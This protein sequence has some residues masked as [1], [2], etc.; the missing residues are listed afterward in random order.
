LTTYTVT[1]SND[2]GSGSLRQAILD[3]N[4]HSGLN[5]IDFFIAGGYHIETITPLAPLPAITNR[6]VLDGTTQVAGIP[7]PGIE[8]SGASAGG[9]AANGLTITAGH[10]TVAGLALT[11]WSGSGLVLQDSGGDSVVYSTF[12]IDPTGT[13][14]EGNTYGISILSG[15]NDLIGGTNTSPVNLISGNAAAGINLQSSGNQIVGNY[16]GTNLEG[17]V[18]IPNQVGVAITGSS[19]TVGGA[20]F[21]NLIS[22]NTVAGI[23]I[24]GTTA[25]NNQILDNFIGTDLTGTVA[26]GN[27]IG[28][29]ITASGNSVGSEGNPNLVSG[30]LGDG[31]LIV[32]DRNVVINDTIGADVTSSLPLGNYNGVDVFGSNNRIGGRAGEENDIG[33]NTNDGV[34]LA[35]T[36]NGLYGNGIGI[37]GNPTVAVP[38]TYGVYI[39]GGSGNFIGGTTSDTPGNYLSGNTA[40]GL[41]IHN[42][43]NNLVQTNAI[44]INDLGTLAFPNNDGVVIDGGT[45]NTIGGTPGT[46]SFNLIGGNFDVG[47]IV[48]SDGNRI[49]GNFIGVDGTGTYAIPNGRGMV[50]LSS[51]N[52]IGG[53]VLG[54]GNLI[55]GNIQEGLYVAGDSNLIQGNAIGTN[56]PENAALPNFNGLIVVGSSNIIGGP[57][58]LVLRNIIS[59]NL[60]VGLELD[61]N[62]NQVQSNFIGAAGDGVRPL[63]NG[64]GIY[65]TG[66]N[67]TIGGTASQ[68]GNT[69]FY[70]TTDGVRVDTGTGNAI[71]GNSMDYHSNGLGIQL[72][73][74]GNNDP[75][76]PGISSAVF[77][78]NIVI[79]GTLQST[80]NTSFTLDFFSTQAPNPSGY[81]EGGFYIGSKT[82]T[83][84]GSGLATFTA[85][86]AIYVAPGKY[87]SATATNPANNTSAFSWDVL[88][89]GTGAPDLLRRG[90]PA[91][92]EGISRGESETSALLVPGPVTSPG[93]DLPSTGKVDSVLASPGVGLGRPEKNTVPWMISGVDR[94]WDNQA[95]DEFLHGPDFD[96]SAWL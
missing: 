71:R 40:V 14:A 29:S 96:W 58:N 42:S 68:A 19:N 84:N 80:P 45:N 26:L 79:T 53:S 77:N 20:A 18:P 28:I 8:L 85:S 56:A 52:T 93:A 86:F 3:A 1:N 32:G 24:A 64:L 21:G 95:G 60:N 83:T 7:V 59:G 57:N 22:G 81:G 82:V 91:P 49:A 25:A 27:G 15:S 76:F 92:P 72:I 46:P 89:T 88:V 5:T 48:F 23:T 16:I 75:V 61:G 4:A 41:Y 12:G 38:N 94:P 13:F 47:L 33:G 51:N 6:V 74:G 9:G 17:T 10:S 87:V 44:G 34:Y 90:I 73:N 43:S 36:G 63:G 54:Q 11:N 62:N 50:V 30:N 65:V 2:S 67:N 37:C 55:S 78:G 66:S 69:I 31:I 39:D 70:N 35:G